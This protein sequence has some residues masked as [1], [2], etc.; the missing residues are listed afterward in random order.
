MSEAK[1]STV[2]ELDRQ[3]VK[4]LKA[5]GDAC[6]TQKSSE[7][8]LLTCV[9]DDDGEKWS[10]QTAEPEPTP[11]PPPTI[12]PTDAPTE[13]DPQGPPPPGNPV[14]L[15]H[16]LSSV[17]ETLKVKAVGDAC[18]TQKSSECG[19]LTCVYDD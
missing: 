6:P 13:A 18:P 11:T 16:D 12:A 2:E 3:E 15:E 4:P 1:A 17:G 5:V 10:C 9:Y 8:G 7:C 14:R 19:L